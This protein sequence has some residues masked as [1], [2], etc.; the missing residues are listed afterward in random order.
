M[1]R[2]LIAG[3]AAVIGVVL[4]LSLVG[5][6][7]QQAIPSYPDALGNDNYIEKI[8]GLYLVEQSAN[9]DNNIIIYGSSELRTLNISTHPV[10]FFKGQRNGIQVNLVGRGSCQSIIHAINIA[11]TGDFLTGKKVVLIT[12]PQS[13]VENGIAPD[14]FVANFSEQQYLTLMLD[15]TLPKEVKRYLSGRVTELTA[16]YNEITGNHIF[17]NDATGMMTTLATNS[18]VSARVADTIMQPYYRFSRWLLDIRD[19]VSSKK[20]IDSVQNLD[21]VSTRTGVQVEDIDWDAELTAAVTE[22]ERLT[23]N[24]DFGMLNDYYTTY[25]GRKL[26]QQKDKD[27]NLSYSVSKEYGDLKVLL[28]ICKLKGI[29]PLFVHVPLHGD[30]SDHTGFDKERREEYYQNVRDIVSQYDNVTMVDLTGYEY[31]E[32][33]LC[34]IMHLGWKGWLEVDKAIEQYY[35][36]D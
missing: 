4:T 35:R 14:M 25:I 34:D 16:E 31:E 8:T 33:F 18:S 32:Y 5:W 21:E 29:E 13:Y 7:I 1:K 2:L 26:E 27:S 30:W 20:L 12:S 23:D 10:N 22:A 24:N 36:E 15:E 3:A 28:D 9:R 6:G 19:L 17:T 11:A